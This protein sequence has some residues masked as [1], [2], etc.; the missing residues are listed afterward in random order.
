MA[1]ENFASEG[2]AESPVATKY[3]VTH[4]D[5]S[6]GKLVLVDVD[7]QDSLALFMDGKLIPSGSPDFVK[8][9]VY[10]YQSALTGSD[11]TKLTGGK[12]EFSL[13][14][15]TQLQTLVAKGSVYA[16]RANLVAQ[17]Y[18]SEA[19]QKRFE[20]AMERDLPGLRSLLACMNG[21]LP[22]EEF[23]ELLARRLR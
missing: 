10:I 12:A 4:I 6:N 13:E 23:V 9:I 3:K 21:N 22:V 17:R 1:G 5:S 16:S 14:E 20:S 8:N 15:L 19:Q 18:G 2:A 7:D 11:I